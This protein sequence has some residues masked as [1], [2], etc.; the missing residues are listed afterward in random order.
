MKVE[1]CLTKSN[2]NPLLRIFINMNTMI[3]V[4]NGLSF[5]MLCGEY[6]LRKALKV[7]KP[8]PKGDN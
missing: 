7:K 2:V 6:G 5:Q 8:F 4:K 1:G 3:G